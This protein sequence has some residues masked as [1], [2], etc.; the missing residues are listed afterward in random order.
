MGSRLSRRSILW[1][2]G[3]LVVMLPAVAAAQRGGFFPF[4]ARSGVQSNVAYDGRFTF[5]RVQYA[6]YGGWAADYPLMERNL[7]TIL[8][9]ITVPGPHVDGTNVHTFDDPDLLKYPIAYLS[10]PG[11]W[12]PERREVLGL[13]HYLE[14]GGFLIVDDF[15]FENEWAVFESRDAARPS[16][17]PGSTGSSSR[18]RSSTR[19]FRSSRWRCRIPAGWRA[20]P[21]GGVPRHPR[22]QRSEPPADGGDQLQHRHR[23]LRGVVGDQNGYALCQPTRRTSL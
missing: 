13:R 2:A 1:I 19:S 16:R 14:K 12:F 11:Y 17:T 20:G 23:R 9:E 21:D 15:H 3:T 18:T 5:V 6:R 22:G 8:Q 10:E 4:G 7:I